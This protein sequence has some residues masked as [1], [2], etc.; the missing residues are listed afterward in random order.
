MHN[1][2][3]SL[4]AGSNNPSVYLSPDGQLRTDPYVKSLETRN[5]A[6]QAALVR[7]LDRIAELVRQE[8]SR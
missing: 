4:Y 2:N 3:I 7:A 5:E 8:V 1:Q 6:L